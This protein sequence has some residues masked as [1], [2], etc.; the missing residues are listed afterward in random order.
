MKA[1]GG[2]PLESGVCATGSELSEKKN[3]K[4]VTKKQVVHQN[5]PSHGSLAS[6][7]D[8]TNI[9]GYFYTENCMHVA[10]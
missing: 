4:S 2:G 9:K 8:P 10:Q 5:N 3:V 7:M 1:Q 6:R